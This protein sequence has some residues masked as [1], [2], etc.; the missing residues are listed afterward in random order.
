MCLPDSSRAGYPAAPVARR[1]AEK[2]APAAHPHCR[3]EDRAI[4]RTPHGHRGL[5]LYTP[6]REAMHCLRD[7]EVRDYL[8]WTRFRDSHYADGRR[9]NPQEF[10]A[11]VGEEE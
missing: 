4:R 2:P 8:E 11:D 5:P 1:R 7:I 10:L 6:L 3:P 9:K